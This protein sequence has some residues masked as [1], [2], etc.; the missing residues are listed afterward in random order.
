MSLQHFYFPLLLFS[1]SNSLPLVLYFAPLSFTVPTT[2]CTTVPIFNTNTSAFHF[3]SPYKREDLPF[4]FIT[5]SYI[6]FSGFAVSFSHFDYQFFHL[7]H[8]SCLYFREEV[9]FYLFLLLTLPPFSLISLYLPFSH[10]KYHYFHL[11]PFFFALFQG[12]STFLSLFITNF[13][14]IFL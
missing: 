2:N 5:N 14:T 3:F 11:S 13:L 9:S 8:F 4:Y 7:S 12:G 1:T 10:A 6:F